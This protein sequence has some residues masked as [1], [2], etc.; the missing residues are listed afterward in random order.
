MSKSFMVAVRCINLKRTR[1]LLGLHRR[2]CLDHFPYSLPVRVSEESAE[3]IIPYPTGGFWCLWFIISDLRL[4][5]QNVGSGIQQVSLFLHRIP[6][7][8][9]DALRELERTSTSCHSSRL[10]ERQKSGEL[11]LEQAKWMGNTVPSVP[12]SRLVP[13][14]FTPTTFPALTE[15]QAFDSLLARF[16]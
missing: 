6:P 10:V 4:L 9:K 1:L 15:L 7:S 3:D 14:N 2:R 5:L 13:P 12:Q 11:S 16:A 8:S